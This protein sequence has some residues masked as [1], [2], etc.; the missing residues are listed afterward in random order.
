MVDKK[1]EAELTNE[2]YANK[3]KELRAQ[4]KL[5]GGEK[6]IA[7]QHG[8]G[9]QT[10]RERVEKL[11]DAGSF[12]EINGMMLN[13]HTDFGLDKGKTLGDGMVTGF[14]TING[15]K[16]C[17]Y[18]QDF[19]VMGG[20]FGEVAGQKVAR[21]QELA[22]DAGVPII[23]IND[24]A[25]ARIQEGVY[26]L[27]GYGEVFYRN[28]QS[29]GVL[30][31]FSV[32][33]GPCAGGAVYSP[34]ITDFIIMTEGT[35][36]MYITGP[37]VIKAVTHEEVDTETLGGA[38]THTS[39]SGVAHFSAPTEDETFA[40]IKKIL[41]YIPDNNTSS[42]ALVATDDSPFRADK[43]LETTV[44]ADPNTTYDVLDVINSVVDLGSFFEVHANFAQNA[45]VGF[46]RMNGESIGVVANQPGYMAG[47][48]DIN[49]SDKIARFVRFCDAF[50][51]PILTFTDCPGFMPG[52]MT[53]HNG[54]IRHGAK[55][56]YAYSE[57]TVPTV[58]VITR[59]AYGG[60]YIAMGSKHLNTDMVFAWPGAEITVMGADGAVN[61]L[62]GRELK[63][64][65][66]TNPEEASAKRAEFLEEYKERFS[67]PY[68][69]AAA[70]YV[71]EVILPGE[72]R[73]RVISALDMLRN[74]VGTAPAKKH[75]NIPL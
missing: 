63:E 48:L 25:G 9:K 21:L 26:S 53:E 71:D 28:V 43:S 1:P 4:M 52:T 10:A 27:W 75:G 45:V 30:P 64:I 50:N 14:G 2:A 36:N 22:M 47:V 37:A 61:I 66:E 17:V 8:K 33:M 72:T 67:N 11:L 39:I 6:R 23:G 42:P 73:Q 38:N 65:K 31:Q 15:R 69:A 40:I 44:P 57:A 74:K 16:V 3:L 54:I 29:S 13:R 41:E 59:K 19:T 46:A 56:L 49:S 58:T 68:K 12:Q 18:A 70:G 55:I 24:G 20:S 7:S 51:L 5:G 35:G 34:A 60:A 62:Y 32:I